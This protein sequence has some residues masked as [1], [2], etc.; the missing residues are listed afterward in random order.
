MVNRGLAIALLSG[1]AV[2]LTGRL[3]RGWHVGRISFGL[4][5]EADRAEQPQ[6]FAL[7]AGLYVFFIL[8]SVLFVATKLLRIW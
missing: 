7:V 2:L 5:V 6:V 1:A 4:W 8:L 3:I